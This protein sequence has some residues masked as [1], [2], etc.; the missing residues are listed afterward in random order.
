MEEV[1][2]GMAGHVP[3]R[4]IAEAIITQYGSDQ[5]GDFKARR[6]MLCMLRGRAGR[7]GVALGG[8]GTGA[9]LGPE[10]LR[11]AFLRCCR[12]RPTAWRGGHPLW[13]L[14]AC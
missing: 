9:R 10:L 5:W 12:R 13:S 3:M 6:A 11:S 1:V 4:A 7:A 14:L 8:G 2:R